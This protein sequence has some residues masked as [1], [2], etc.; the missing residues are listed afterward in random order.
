MENTAADFPIV[1]GERE[2]LKGN[3]AKDKKKRIVLLDVLRGVLMLWVF[4]DH[5]LYNAY[6]LFWGDFT[7]DAGCAL[8]AFARAYWYG[9]YRE[10]AHPIVLFLFFCLSGLVTAFSRNHWKRAV[11]T[12]VCAVGL[13][14]ITF[15]ADLI[16]RWGCTITIGVL[17]AFAVCDFVV[18][19]LEQLKI[20]SWLY[21][22][23]GII[24]SAIGL[25]YCYK[26]DFLSDKLFFLVFDKAFFLSNATADYFPILPYLGYFFLGTFIGKT[27][28]KDKKAKIPLG[29]RAEKLLCPISFIGRT[30]LFWYFSSQAIFVAV[31]Y[32]AILLGIL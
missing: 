6:G 27:F 20:K 21:L 25:A 9:T 7:T 1:E 32:A 12:A 2:N 19:G 11:K 28:Y 17:Y 31:L 14:A 24:L 30:S 4:V 18:F 29:E 22:V 10:I 3:G 15:V 8:A 5:F 23:L 16:F 26:I 13:F